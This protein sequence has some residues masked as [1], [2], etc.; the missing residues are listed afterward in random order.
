MIEKQINA[1]VSNSFG[2]DLNG[3]SALCCHLSPK[4]SIQVILGIAACKPPSSPAGGESA[5]L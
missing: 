1:V 2:S 3:Y 4:Y 5:H